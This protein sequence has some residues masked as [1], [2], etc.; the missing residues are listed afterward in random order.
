M[1]FEGGQMPIQRRMPKTGFTSRIGRV[2]DEIRLG[3]LN[4]ITD[5]VITI[6]SLRKANLITSHIQRVKVIL[7][8]KINNAVTLQG[9]GVT[10]GARDAIVQA[11]G[12]VE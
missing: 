2:T 8:G 9:L 5:S 6:D 3:E 4:A 10:K 12:K 1:G 11:G 7:C